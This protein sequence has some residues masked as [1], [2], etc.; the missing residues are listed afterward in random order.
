MVSTDVPVLSPLHCVSMMYSVWTQSA[1]VTEIV[2]GQSVSVTL[3]GL[4]ICVRVSTA[5]ALTALDM[6]T[7]PMVYM[8]DMCLLV[9]ARLVGYFG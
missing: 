7:A 2:K 6:A 3:H 9:E 4:E 1:E 8:A 5:P